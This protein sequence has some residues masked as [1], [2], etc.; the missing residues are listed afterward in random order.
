[1]QRN[2]ELVSECDPQRTRAGDEGTSLT[3][4]LRGLEDYLSLQFFK[5]KLIIRFDP[6]LSLNKNKLR[7]AVEKLGMIY[8]R[9]PPDKLVSRVLDTRVVGDTRRLELEHLEDQLALLDFQEEGLGEYLYFLIALKLRYALYLE[10][11]ES[12]MKITPLTE[13]MMKS[14][15][16]DDANIDRVVKD[17]ALTL[18]IT[19]KA[20]QVA[21]EQIM[22]LKPRKLSV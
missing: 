21:Q 18:R 13:L 1:M 11:I 6:K 2:T 20:R 17:L 19:S 10:F 7:E 9:L 14:L 12:L 16:E 4:R 15:K 5:T 22:H 3:V 8:N